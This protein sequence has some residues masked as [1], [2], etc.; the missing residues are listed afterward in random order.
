M[1]LLALNQRTF[2]EAARRHPAGAAAVAA[3]AVGL[4]LWT[5][6]GREV[7]AWPVEA[8]P[9]VQRVVSS[10]RVRPPARIN[11]ASL[12]IGRVARVGAREGDRVAAGQ[13]LI[14]LEDAEA[15][16]SLRQA[17]GKVA[18]AAARLE[19]VRGVSGRLAAEGLR[20]AELKVADAEA[21]LSRARQLND[22]G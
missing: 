13:V 4:V 5:V 15:A 17:Q 3:A 11:L 19:Q 9:I 1:S 10:G 16:A 2:F 6:R 14:Q 22:A 8:H 18:E 20:Q 12:V 21:A 7:P